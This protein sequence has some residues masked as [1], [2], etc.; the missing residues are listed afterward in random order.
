MCE[1]QHSMV[2]AAASAGVVHAIKWQFQHRYMILETMT[3]LSDDPTGSL[4]NYAIKAA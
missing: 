4:P 2:A 3:R 1:G